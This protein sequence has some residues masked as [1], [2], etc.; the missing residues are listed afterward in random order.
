MTL[1][2]RQAM[3]NP[4]FHGDVFQSNGVEMIKQKH[5]QVEDNG[6]IRGTIVQDRH[7][8]VMIAGPL[9]LN[10]WYFVYLIPKSTITLLDNDLMDS[11]DHNEINNPG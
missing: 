3:F 2:G 5:P 1:V 4:V 6:E 9:E 10:G 8:D 11:N 7:N